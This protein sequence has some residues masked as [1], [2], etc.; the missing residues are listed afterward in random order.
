MGFETTAFAAILLAHNKASPPAD[1]P[2]EVFTGW[3]INALS[4]AAPLSI[5]AV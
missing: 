3:L 5:S 2:V 1:A 4:Y